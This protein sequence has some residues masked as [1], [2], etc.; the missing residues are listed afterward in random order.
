MELRFIIGG[1]G[2]SNAQLQ[3][4]HDEDATHGALL[5]LSHVQDSDTALS[6]PNVFRVIVQRL[7]TSSVNRICRFFTLYSLLCVRAS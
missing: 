2:L 5:L 1:Q 7:C 3:S 4:V 6:Y